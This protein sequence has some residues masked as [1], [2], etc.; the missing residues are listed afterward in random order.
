MLAP[1]K[2]KFRKH[3]RGR[4]QFKG[5]SKGGTQL[6]FGTIGLKAITTSEIT[7]RQIEAGRRAITN[8]LKRGGKIWIRVFPHKII[9][10]KSGE[11]PMGSGKGAPDKHVDMVKKGR[12][13][14]EIDGVTSELAKEALRRAG[15]K[16]PVQ[17]KII[18]R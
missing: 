9:T 14:Y 3:F 8:Y 5:S 4:G 2:S 15:N 6:N 10:S 13:I 1:K 11:T 16:L 17:W 7:S 18:E 12:I